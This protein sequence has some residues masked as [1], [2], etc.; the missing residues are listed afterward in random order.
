MAD[1]EVVTKI[2]KADK[3]QAEP[4]ELIIETIK[5]YKGLDKLSDIEAE[6][7]SASLKLFTLLTYQLFDTNK[8]LQDG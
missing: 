1:I 4:N 6:I 8:Y 7:V 5:G 2:R 3:K